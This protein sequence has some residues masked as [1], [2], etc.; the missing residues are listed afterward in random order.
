MASLSKQLFR[1]SALERLSSPEQLDQ[2]LTVTSPKGWV[3]LIALWAI[4]ACVVVWSIFGSIPTTEE[5]GGILVFRGGLKQVQAP[6]AG[7]LREISVHVGDTVEK[8]QIVAIIDRQDLLDQVEDARRE[9][10]K[11][12]E[13]DEQ[14]AALD[15]REGDLQ[16]NLARVENERLDRAVQFSQERIVR[17]TA[18]RETIAGLVKDGNMTPID[19]ERIEEEI[20]QCRADT[21]QALLQKEQV[22]AKNSVASFERERSRTERQMK[23]DGL[24]SG[25]GMLWA[26]FER[27][28]KVRAAFAGRVVEVRAAEQTALATGDPVLLIEPSDT[29]RGALEAVVYVSAATGKRIEVGFP[30]DLS[31][32]TVKQEEYGSL[33][34]KVR[35]VADVP[36][37]RQAMLAVL[38]DAD[39][40]ER[41]T[42]EIGLPL[43]V[44]VDLEPDTTTVSG[45][46]WTSSSGPDIRISPGTLCRA[47]VTVKTQAPIRMVIPLVKRG[48]GG[49]E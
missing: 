10:S 35:S 34:G 45:Y 16:A 19:I 2:L 37:S 32:S 28:A 5:G 15:L 44:I 8:D 47:S 30:V 17:L 14:A 24:D 23:I 6:A 27:E 42:R 49:T 29:S 41:F 12:R 7:R 43:Q 39:L 33:V 11:L 26:R 20:E 40:V 21:R 1:E 13:Q 46:K 18:R 48:I 38:S 4:L 3:S 22:A 25:V 36:T 31:P 9:L